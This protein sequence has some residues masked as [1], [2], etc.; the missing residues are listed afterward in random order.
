M[1]GA[2]GFVGGALRRSLRERHAVRALTRSETRAS[3]PGD[4]PHEEWRQCDLFSL[5]QV[6]E[7]LAGAEIA[8]YLVHS[9]LPSARLNQGS[10]EDLDLQLAENFAEGAERNGLKHVIFLSGLLPEDDRRLSGHLRSRAEVENTLC[11]YATPVTVL[12]TGIVVGPGGSSL[13]MLVNLVRRLPVMLLPQWV[14]ATTC[15]IAIR[16]VVRAFERVVAESPTEDRVYDIGYPETVNYGQLI[17]RA[18]EVLGRRRIYIPLPISSPNISKLWIRLFS[19]APAALVGPL[20]DSLKHSLHLRPN[21][22]Q[23]ALEGSMQPF[24][25]ALRESVDAHGRP[26]PNARSRTQQTDNTMIREARRVRSMQRVVAPPEFSAEECAQVYFKWLGRS[27]RWFL[28]VEEGSQGEVSII[29]RGI[30]QSLLRLAPMDFANTPRHC[31]YAIVGGLLANP[32]AQPVGRFEFRKVLEGNALLTAI[33]GYRPRLPWHFY[34]LTQAI[35]HLLVMRAFGGY[36]RRM[37]ARVKRGEA[38]TE[39]AA[40]LQ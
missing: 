28:R 24:E 22:L 30:R 6:T 29:V 21:P 12:R 4:H 19:G 35:L 7:A 34:N 15:Y 23:A 18:S 1:A 39:L 14:R 38:T 20:V 31:A 32:H 5:Q 27:L 8:I 40:A 3:Q 10:F 13:L 26:L 37:A 17:R 16:D 25:E 11:N 36:M 2:S 9:M 33:H